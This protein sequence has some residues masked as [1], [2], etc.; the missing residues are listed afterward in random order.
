MSRWWQP[1]SQRLLRNV[2]LDVEFYDAGKNKVSQS[3]QTGFNFTA[4]QTISTN[5]VSFAPGGSGTY[6]VAIGVFSADGT[7][8]LYWNG[9]AQTFSVTPPP[10]VPPVPPCLPKIAF[11]SE[12]D[13]VIPTQT[14]AITTRYTNWSIW[15]CQLPAGY[16]TYASLFNPDQS[17][18]LLIWNYIKGMWTLAQAQASA[19][20]N[21]QPT[22]S[23]Q[24]YLNTLMAKYRPIA[25]VAFNGANTTRSVYTTNSDGTLNPTPLQ[26]ETVAVATRCDET[27]RIPTSP[28]YYSV[29]GQND[30]NAQPLKPGSFAV[31]VLSFP[32][33]PN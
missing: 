12:A 4:G 1:S 15:V 13:D 23:E 3:W 18:L 30:Q 19:A 22:P 28:T 25:V 33:R 14:P 29:A 26:G 6:T 20:Y 17:T 24:A 10:Y 32:I 9:A 21:L 7:T 27:S 16:Q 8:N 5:S 2:I 11:G 31:C